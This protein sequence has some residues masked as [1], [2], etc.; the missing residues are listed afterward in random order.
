MKAECIKEKFQFAVTKTEKVTGKNMTLPVLGCILIEAKDN[1]LILR[2]T[3][4]DLGIEVRVPAKVSKAGLVAVPGQVLNG[5]LSNLSDDGSVLLEE[6]E[7]NLYIESSGSHAVIKSLPT[8]DFPTI[9]KITDGKE[10]EIS[11]LDFTEGLKSVWYSASTSSVKPELSSVYI[12]SDGEGLVF[13]ATDSFRLAEKKVRV[14]KIED[15]GQVLIPF[16]NVADILKIIGDE[17]DILT[18]NFT[19]NQVSFKYRDVYLVSRVID[20]LFPDYKQIIPKEF[21]TEVIVLKKDLLN[22]LKMSNIFTDS[23]NQMNIKVAPENKI[24][25]F[26][27]KNSSVGENINRMSATITGEPIEINFNHKYIV[28]CFQSVNS[29]SLTLSFNGLNKPLLIKGVSDKTF[30]YLVMPMNR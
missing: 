12:Y 26:K 16:K 23:F 4:L 15:F 2:S 22:V 27:T 19:K 20:G 8:D 9:P 29:D 7:G 13:V 14:K 3:N 24:L 6:R 17:K 5:F 25:E 30:T 21:K 11:S 10:Y 18:V 28:D 1:A